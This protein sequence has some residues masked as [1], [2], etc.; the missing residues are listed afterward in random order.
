MDILQLLAY[1]LGL[2]SLAGV[3]LYL[4]VFAAGIAVRLG[5][6]VLPERLHELSV[7]GDTWV[8]AVAGAFFIL[9][10]FADKI[11]WVDS[12]WDSLHTFI[13]PIGA[14][15]L[16]ILALGD[17]NPIVEVLAALAAGGVALT[18]HTAKA[19]FR[20]VANA[21][22]E[23]FSNIGLS[24][25]GDTVVLGGLALI[26]WH[27]VIALVVCIAALAMIWFF[28]PR[29]LR[30]AMA[31]IWLAWRKLNDPPPGRELFLAALKPPGRV[32]RAVQRAYAG[33]GTIV[34]ALPCLS[35]SGPR[36]PSNFLG[37]LICV[38]EDRRLAFIAGRFL[39]GELIVEIPMKGGEMRQESRFLSEKITVTSGS[40]TFSF[41]LERGHR[42]A[43][44]EA[45]RLLSPLQAKPAVALEV[46]GG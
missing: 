33:S 24:I 9:E 16:A 22:P 3:N 1:A 29:L 41:Y 43:A 19:S 28:L 38:G 18:T 31:H 46:A 11:P 23:P 8:I 17:A 34:W 40:E 37:W 20:L 35:G 26:G 36:M 21:S 2:A 14:A 42:V 12:L 45:I 25:A 5:W 6:V 15:F 30:A 7:L 44:E 27:P 32:V 10:F 4:T 39:R 13:R